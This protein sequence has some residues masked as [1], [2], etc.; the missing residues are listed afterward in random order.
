[1]L[2]ALLSL[3]VLAAPAMSHASA[4]I[5]PS[6]IVFLEDDYRGAL[7]KAR[8]E[9][10][11]LFLDSWATWCHSCLSMRSF[12]FP[13]AGLRPAKD[14]VV[15][16]SVET[17]AEKNREV[18]EKFP[19][20]GLPTFLLIDPFTEQVIG[21]WLGTSSVNE[22]REFVLSTTA[23]WQASRKG[24][25]VSEAALAVQQGHAAQLR[26]D[27]PGAAAAY[28]RAVALSSRKD[29]MRPE[30]VALFVAALRHVG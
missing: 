3:S 9:K 4:A 17:E 2:S 7:A 26:G 10:K 5:P 15:W 28:R 30:R 16:L 27:R 8:A 21:R 24:G 25:K 13:D 18:V 6:G 29:P 19:A 22:M 23:A 1:M 12:V 20:D 14:A 11:P